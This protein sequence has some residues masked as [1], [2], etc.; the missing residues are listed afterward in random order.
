MKYVK[1]PPTEYNLSIGIPVYKKF[2]KPIT[3][4]IINHQHNFKESVYFSF[5]SWKIVL[6]SDLKV[7]RERANGV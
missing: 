1:N 4:T 3:I 5:G 6:T 7:T 2:L